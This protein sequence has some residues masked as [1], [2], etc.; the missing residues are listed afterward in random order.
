MAILLS[1]LLGIAVFVMTYHYMEKIIDWFRFHS[2]GT[3]DFIV[4]KCNLMFIDA[5]PNRV[6]TYLIVAAV[7]PF[8]IVFLILLPNFIAGVIFGLMAAAAGWKLPKPIINFMYRRRIN[9]F[10]I[11][12]VDGLNLM[13]NGLKSGLSVVQ[14][15]GVVADQMP[16]PMSEEF[17]L[18]LSQNKVG[19]PV[20]EAFSNLAKRVPCEDVDMFVTSVNI[21]KETGGNLSETFET[22]VYTIRER[23]KVENKISAMTMQG[24]VQG[25]TLLAV[26][27]ALG[28]YFTVSEPGFMDPVFSNPLGWILMVMIIGLEV[29]AY[30][31]IT[32]AIKVDV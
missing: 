2:L 15:L 19:V 5:N 16:K 23:L 9:T 20:E 14:S 25:M 13:A 28:V 22:I 31:A 26:A 30:Y 12:M 8:V 24:F 32:R 3:R 7:G 17:N 4:E 27:P 10:N 6:L 11:Q 1:G 21:L 29:I 18:V